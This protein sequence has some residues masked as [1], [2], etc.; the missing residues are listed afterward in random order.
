MDT[1]T[2]QC[3]LAVL[4]SGHGSSRSLRGRSWPGK[5]SWD[6]VAAGFKARG[7]GAGRVLEKLGRLMWVSAS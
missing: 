6:E 3:A 4:W 1:T 5:Q 7:R 2:E